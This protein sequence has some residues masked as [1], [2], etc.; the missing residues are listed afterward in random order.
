M[1]YYAHMQPQKPGERNYWQPTE[2]EIAGQ[3]TNVSA[4]P[5]PAA[6][7]TPA[8]VAPPAPVLPPAPPVEPVATPAESFTPPPSLDQM[9]DEDLP[10][11]D[12]AP[13]P[14]LPDEVIQWSAAEFVQHDKGILWFIGLGIAGIVMLAISIL[15]L[16]DWFFAVIIVILL[17]GIAFVAVRPP[18]QLQ[19]AIDDDGVHIG[20]T[21][22]PY[23]RFHAFSLSKEESMWCVI[24]IPNARFS[25]TLT[26]YFNEAQGEDIVDFL[27]DYLPMEEHKVD[28][29]DRLSRK[30]RF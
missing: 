10:D 5:Q 2:G 1:L 25:P 6:P 4:P 23:Q 14:V 8:P 9:V 26:L 3:A 24:L 11:T 12:A 28:I 13:T 27:G 19:Y 30:L 18:R 15:L 7:V 16:K 29:V 22:Y 21:L 17:V 20:A